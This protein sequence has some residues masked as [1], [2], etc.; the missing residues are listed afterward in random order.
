MKAFRNKFSILIILL[1]TLTLRIKG[2]SL[3]LPGQVAEPMF[4]FQGELIFIYKN[5][6]EKINL[7]TLRSQTD[8]SSST[9][10][11]LGESA[12]SPV[13]KKD[14]RGQI[15]V[16]WEEWEHDQ[17][18]ILFGQLEENRV[19]H[20]QLISD[21]Q[22]FNISPDLSFDLNNNP[23]IV[24][25]NYKDAHYR[26][27]VQDILFQKT[28]IINSPFL[29]SACAPQV[30]TDLQNRVWVFWSGSDKKEGIFYRVFDQ[31]HWSPLSKVNREI[32]YPQI[33]PAIALDMNGFIWVTWSGYDGQD[34]EI[35][36]KFW[37][38][39]KWSKIIRITDNSQ[40]D[41]AFP[42]VSI[43]SNN[44]P[45]I[46]WTQSGKEGSHI[47]VKFLEN[48]SWSI[49]IQI[50]LARGQNIF[51]RMAAEGEKIGIVWQSQEEIKARIFSLN[52]LREK[53]VFDISPLSESHIIYNP[54]LDENKY[55]G[56]GDSI[57][58][59]Y[60]YYEEAPDK[61]YIPRLE[62]LLDQNFGETEVANEGRPGEITQNG[63]GRIE[64]VIENHLARYLLLMEGTND[65]VF[66]RISM[67]TTAFNLEQI[68]KKCID[69]GVF[70]AIATIIPR[71]DRRWDNTFFRDRIFYL[72]DKIREL[73]EEFPIP[74][75]DQFNLFYYY[76]EEEGGWRS[77]LSDYNHPTEEGYQLMA[78]E[79]FEEIKNFPFPPI[80]VQVQRVFN[81][82][83]FY[84]E[85]GNY[86]SWQ[87]N[88][89][90]YNRDRVQGY[91]IYRKKAEEENSQFHLLKIIQNQLNYFDS[92]IIPSTQYV[93]SISTLRTDEV[94]GPCSEPKKDH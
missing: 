8:K 28:W 17:S 11:H 13:I 51:P 94:E 27:F 76:P 90:I 10:V 36:C 22:G 41:D 89:K 23:W 82:I 44:I 29:S 66:K 60:L 30:V 9:T 54:S 6:E 86:I 93:Y 25:I 18:R 46:A 59:G 14:N 73:A 84:R 52:Q 2:D 72:N 80:G 3:I 74:L 34:Y 32:K 47:Q 85:L 87:E 69:F 91:K 49:G 20:S 1:L 77:L 50:S 61:G 16:I 75:A 45:I 48:D 15:W 12:F 68:V 55:I 67:D 63:L 57:T 31:Y 65:V 79:W 62:I 58:Y 83:L 4:N 53:N 7:E 64:S 5:V 42:S 81:E 19:I 35:Y 37:N 33:S 39:E 21:E 70:S 56:F 40:K 24:W 26:V 71:K 38:G 92:D 78:E 88:P 43:A